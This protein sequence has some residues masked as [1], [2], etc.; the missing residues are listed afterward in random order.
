MS[1]TKNKETKKRAEGKEKRRERIV[2]RALPTFIQLDSVTTKRF[3][4]EQGKGEVGKETENANDKE[5]AREK[6]S[7]KIHTHTPQSDTPPH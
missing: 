7:Y 2:N 5:R 6:E 3:F 1:T 4:F